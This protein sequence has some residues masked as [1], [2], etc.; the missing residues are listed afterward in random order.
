LE[1][2]ETFEYIKAV[3]SP[4]TRVCT[5]AASGSRRGAL[6]LIANLAPVTAYGWVCIHFSP[7]VL[8]P[9]S[10]VTIKSSFARKLTYSAI[11]LQLAFLQYMANLYLVKTDNPHPKQD[12]P[13]RGRGSA[14]S[15]ERRYRYPAEEIWQVS[16]DRWQVAES[17]LPA[18][19]N[20]A[21]V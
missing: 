18:G 13:R 11:G 12:A 17:P 7:A 19:K 14:V 3:F 20:R 9:T 4:V 16:E 2:E 21:E 1:A 8:K 15:T 6:T 10:T 5:A